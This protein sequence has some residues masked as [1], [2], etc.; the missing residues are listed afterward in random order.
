MSS[1][2]V[3]MTVSFFFYFQIYG[4]R[5]CLTFVKQS[6]LFLFSPFFVMVMIMI[7]WNLLEYLGTADVDRELIIFM[8][9]ISTLL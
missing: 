8:A 4:S 7:Q 6:V 2:I 1:S 3:G 5:K 9:Q